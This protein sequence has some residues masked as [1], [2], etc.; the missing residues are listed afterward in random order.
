MKMLFFKENP[1]WH[2]V[3][4][5]THVIYQS[6]INDTISLMILYP[7]QPLAVMGILLTNLE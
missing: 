6:N 7:I 5:Q 1:F 3:E 2:G 4:N